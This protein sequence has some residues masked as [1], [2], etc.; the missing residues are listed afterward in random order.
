M[1]QK[2]SDLL[3]RTDFFPGLGWMIRADMALELLGDY[4]PDSY[5]DDWLRRPEVRQNRVCIR[6]EVTRTAHNNRLAG[7]GSS[8]GMYKSYLASIQLPESAVDFTL[9]NMQRLEKSSYDSIFRQTNLG[10]QAN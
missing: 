1:D 8:N 3:Y 9:V 4:W 7:K 5:W 2:R 10:R 6:P